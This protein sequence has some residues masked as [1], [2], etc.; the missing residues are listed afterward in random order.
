MKN[1][2]TKKQ[3]SLAISCAMALVVLS[4]TA[5]AETNP[6][7][8]GYLDDQR[9]TVVKSGFGLCWHNGTGPAPLSPNECDS[10]AAQAP[11]A[12]LAEP[13]Q[14][15]VQLAA[16]TPVAKPA[17]QR[18]TLDADTLFD[19]NKA[20]LR[21]AGRTALDDFVV[22]TRDISP[23]VIMAVGHADRFGSE[24]YNQQLSEHRA[25]AVKAY[26]I[27]KGIAA[28]RLQTEGKGETQPVTK[29]GECNGA[30][31]AKV[32]ACLQPDRRVD[33]EVVGTRI[34]M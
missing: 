3:S 5:R 4:G 22:K 15:P 16:V 20:V 6:A 12:K 14:K 19:F 30:K 10:G 13:A 26:L 27:G 8:T 28:N 29:A 21:P 31:S 33:V 2:F 1:T 34:A 25:E 23:E 18:V 11:I 32:I 7:D 17:A 9:G 24:G